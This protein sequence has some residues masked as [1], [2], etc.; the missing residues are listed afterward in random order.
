MTDNKPRDC[1]K[2]ALLNQ[3]YEQTYKKRLLIEIFGEQRADNII[4]ISNSVNNPQRRTTPTRRCVRDIETGEEEC[5]EIPAPAPAQTFAVFTA[6]RTFGGINYYFLYVFN[7]TKNPKEELFVW[8]SDR[9]FSKQGAQY[10]VPF[11]KAGISL[12]GMGVPRGQCMNGIKEAGEECEIAIEKLLEDNPSCSQATSEIINGITWTRDA[13]GSCGLNCKCI[14]DSPKPDVS[15]MQQ[16]A[17]CV[18]DNQCSIKKERCIKGNCVPKTYCGDGIV[19]KVNDDGIAEECEPGLLD[20]YAVFGVGDKGQCR[21]GVSFCSQDCKLSVELLGEVKPDLAERCGAGFGDGID[22]DCNGKTDEVC[23]CQLGINKSCGSNVGQC[24]KGVQTCTASEPNVMLDFGGMYGYDSQQNYPNPITNAMSCPDGYKDVKISDYHV[25]CYREHIE[26]R[27]PDYD[28]G[29]MYGLNPHTFIGSNTPILNPIDETIDL[30][31]EIN[32]C[33]EGYESAQISVSKVHSCN[34]DFCSYKPALSFCYRNHKNDGQNYY[35]GGMYS[36]RSVYTKY[37]WSTIYNY[38]NP[39]TGMDSCPDGYLSGKVDAVWYHDH[40]KRCVLGD[41]SCWPY[42][43]RP[44]II[45]YK[46][47]T[48]GVLRWSKCEGEVLPQ[49]EKCDNIDNNC[50]GIINENALNETGSACS[51][52]ASK[53]LALLGQ[54]PAYPDTG[55]IMYRS[56]NVSRGFG[57]PLAFVPP[58]ESAYLDVGL[59]NNTDYFYRVLGVNGTYYSVWSNVANATTFA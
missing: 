8:Q 48:E 54:A 15:A 23:T 12:E 11:L 21:R 9:S 58:T 6:N 51:L 3:K 24:K 35:F 55:F 41:S 43:P 31:S 53:E 49:P 2:Y 59:L 56:R 30:S 29:G 25:L 4:L 13:H 47:A 37:G 7:A 18:S 42:Y 50:N 27:E 57:S 28:F 32:V 19:Q 17:Q 34:D 45:C 14:Y 22:N 39:A 16:G 38:F 10:L 5:T 40:K 20:S 46:N 1:Y 26:G 36:G 44:I 52:S 33:P